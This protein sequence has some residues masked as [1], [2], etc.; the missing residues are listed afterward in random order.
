M[1]ALQIRRVSIPAVEE[2]QN[3]YRD[4]RQQKRE[5]SGE[6]KEE[7]ARREG[8]IERRHGPRENARIR[9]RY[10]HFGGVATEALDEGVEQ[11]TCG[12]LPR[13]SAAAA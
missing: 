1:C 2:L 10:P 7:I 4:H 3:R 9:L 11:R 5:H 6:D 13:W 12:R 8:W